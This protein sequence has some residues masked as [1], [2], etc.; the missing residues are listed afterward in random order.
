MQNL[1]KDNTPRIKSSG[2][3]EICTIHTRKNLGIISQNTSLIVL[4]R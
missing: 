4:M 2:M 3:Q 1:N